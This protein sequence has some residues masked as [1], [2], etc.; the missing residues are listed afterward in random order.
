MV[1]KTE[2]NANTHGTIADA[3]ASAAAPAHPHLGQQ[4]ALERS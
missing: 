1:N 2:T 3:A 4:M